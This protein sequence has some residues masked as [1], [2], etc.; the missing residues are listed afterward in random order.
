MRIVDKVRSLALGALFICCSQAAF[1]QAP[2]API[3]CPT[4][5]VVN[6]VVCATDA[7]RQQA[8]EVE[9][10][11]FAAA[12][13]DFDETL[14]LR[15]RWQAEFLECGHLIGQGQRMRTCIAESFERFGVR[16]TAVAAPADK[17]REQLFQDAYVI[18]AAAGDMAR[19]NRLDCIQ[20]E[21]L[22]VD[23][24]LSSARD[25]AVVVAKRCRKA[26]YNVA[27]LLSAEV[28]LALPFMTQKRTSPGETL[29]VVDSLSE[30]DKLI[31]T[32]L[33]QRAAKR[34]LAP[35]PVQKTRPPKTL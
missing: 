33:E 22:A 29:S 21:A 28:E 4:A 34:K 7:L 15:I 27:R 23:D 1:S 3:A 30:P 17:P 5:T 32:V 16:L 9:R 10:Q 6:E 31:E 18:L 35:P 13:A 24:G 25:I 12:A 26:S 8:F 19:Q 14:R 20:R 2:A 11:Y